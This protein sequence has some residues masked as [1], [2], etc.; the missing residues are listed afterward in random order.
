MVAAAT[1]LL[2][3]GIVALALGLGADDEPRGRSVATVRDAT[4]PQ[5]SETGEHRER[6]ARGANAGAQVR[7][8]VERMPIEDRV[9]QLFLLGFEGQDLTAPIFERLRERGIGGIAIDSHNYLSGDQ[10]ASLTGEARVIA[11]QE[12]HVAPW[13]LAPQEGG[14]FNAFPGLPPATAA[15]DL[16]S[17]AKA[18][19]EAVDA[20]TAL[21]AVG[22]NGVLAPVVDVAAPNAAAVGE[23][24]FSDDPR[25]VAGYAKAVVDAYRGDSMLTAPG[26]F[27]GLGAGG[28]DTRLGLSQVG[29]S[30]A[31]L[32]SRDLVPFRAAIRAGAPAITMSNGLYVTDDFVTPGSLSPA[33]IGGLLRRELGFRGIVITDDLADPG[34]T[35]LTEVPKAAVD[36]LQAGADLLYVSAPPA[37]QQAAFEAVLGA[38]QSGTISPARLQEAL[39][40]NLSVKRNYSLIR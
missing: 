6:R 11:E 23:R 19:D 27:P 3:A 18:F 40:R 14:E 34:V 24:A 13:L 26:H 7:A 29:S 35:S 12:G 28:G 1:T 15:A 5:A 4:Q 22:L 30:L 37:E 21:R 38:A 20:A 10:L 2:A 8:L 33:L 25:D 17:A 31:A 32:R 36:A 9:A 16:P 39:L